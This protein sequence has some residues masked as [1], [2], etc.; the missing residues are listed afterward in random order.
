MPVP[1]TKNNVHVW[2]KKGKHHIWLPYKGQRLQLGRI[3]RFGWNTYGRSYTYDTIAKHN[4]VDTT[5]KQK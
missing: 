3:F 5:K 4:S 2:S 1:I